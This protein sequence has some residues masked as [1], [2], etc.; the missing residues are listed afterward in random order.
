M[1]EGG[2]HIGQAGGRPDRVLGCRAARRRVRAGVQPHRDGL[3]L[4]RVRQLVPLAE[5]AG[6]S[7][8]ELALAWVLHTPNVSAAER[9]PSGIDVFEKRP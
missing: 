2:G 7:L 1:H 9:D 3:G 4:R 8:T 6:L 5:D